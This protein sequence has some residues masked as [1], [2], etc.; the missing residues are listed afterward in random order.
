MIT[1]LTQPPHSIRHTLTTLLLNSPLPSH[2]LNIPTTLYGHRYF[3]A[4]GVDTSWM[5]PPSRADD[6]NGFRQSSF[7]PEVY[8]AVSETTTWVPA[9]VYDCPTGYHW[10]TTA[11]AHQRFTSYQLVSTIRQWHSQAKRPEGKPSLVLLSYCSHHS[12]ITLSSLSY[13]SLIALITLIIMT[14]ITVLTQAL[15]ITSIF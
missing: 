1:I 4:N 6:C 12:P 7:D 10:A 13:C 8:F 9:R 5:L 15:L 3:G 11:E 14:M 2:Y